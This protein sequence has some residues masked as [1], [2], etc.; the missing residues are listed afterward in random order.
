MRLI[1][2]HSGELEEFIG[3]DVPAYA[4]LSH[5][6]EEGEVSYQE[7]VSRSNMHKRGWKK[8]G[9]ACELASQHGLSYVWVDTC[10]IDKSSSAELSESINSM[11]RWYRDSV[12]CFAW[13]VDWAADGKSDRGMRD[14]RW[15]KRG[16][17]LQ[18]LIAPST[19]TFFDSEWHDR[20][21]KTK[22]MKHLVKAT[23]ISEDLLQGVKP[24][25]AFSVARKM[26]WAAGRK[27]TRKEDA[28][29]SL[30]GL[31]DL[32]MPLLYGEGDKA[33]RRLQEEIIRTTHD[34][35]IFAWKLCSTTTPV[36]HDVLCGV[37]AISPLE[38]KDSHDCD[39][40]V[41]GL[42][43]FSTSNLG[44]KIRSRLHFSD[45]Q[46]MGRGY[47]MPIGV[48][49]NTYLGIRVR[50]IGHE[51][52][53]REDPFTVMRYPDMRFGVASLLVEERFLLDRL[54]G[55]TG[56]YSG[57]RFGPTQS[58]LATE[59]AH[60]LQ[61]VGRPDMILEE[62][63]PLYRF[64]H[65]DGAFFGSRNAKRDYITA[66]V[67]F[68]GPSPRPIKLRFYG[69]DWYKRDPQHAQFSLVDEMS[70]NSQSALV[71]AKVEEYDH[72]SRQFMRELNALEV[73]R[74][75]GV[76]VKLDDGMD[77][78]F[79]FTAESC[80]DASVCTNMYWKVTFHYEIVEAEKAL[81]IEHFKWGFTF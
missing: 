43:D 54:P 69:L 2:V 57:Q 6:W 5:T 29:Y 33:F 19:I 52:Y 35:T 39:I 15:F 45:N 74:Q 56:G 42:Q 47:L 46:R 78:L 34:L 1:N 17:T 14:C 31:F 76:L 9:K 77:A 70:H 64:N 11:Y 26:S 73:P 51:Q 23:R 50:K 12:H 24:L 41:S 13:L 28:A 66:V 67:T 21:T 58:I 40:S 59:R 16:W 36:F 63:W 18:E 75:S 3:D 55:S 65:E 61:F 80:K 10:C 81:E 49:G 62:Q 37:F 20:G 60:V 27:T 72:N 71:K 79:S 30:L 7:F 68:N 44:V 32:N 8:I 48:V 53:L 4:I 22:L 38:F 25:S